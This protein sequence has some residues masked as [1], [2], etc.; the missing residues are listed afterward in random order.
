ML[1]LFADPLSKH[2]QPSAVTK[3][4]RLLKMP[5]NPK[6]GEG[7]T[8]HRRYVGAILI[9]LASILIGML[10]SFNVHSPRLLLTTLQV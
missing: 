4:P 1:K 8:F 6:L 2:L 9:L 3:T 7:C 10:P 5:P